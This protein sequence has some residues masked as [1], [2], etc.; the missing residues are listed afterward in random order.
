MNRSERRHYNKIKGKDSKNRKTPE[1][2]VVDKDK[3]NLITSTLIGVAI[4]VI[5]CVLLCKSYYKMVELSFMIFIHFIILNA[6]VITGI[7]L[8]KKKAK[9]LKTTIIFIVEY[10]I[11]G[12]ILLCTHTMTRY[13]VLSGNYESSLTLEEFK[14][15]A[16][17]TVTSES[18]IDGVWSD[19]IAGTD[20]AK[21]ETPQLKYDGVPGAKFYAIYMLDESA[22]NW[23]HWREYEVKTTILRQG[24]ENEN[25]D[26]A[27][28]N[29]PKGSGEHKYVVYVFALRD[30]PD[31][32]Y[33]GNFY[34]AGMGAEKYYEIDLDIAGKKRGNVISYGYLEGT[35]SQ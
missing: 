3:I 14:K 28:P 4:T 12:Y 35:Y 17:L 6:F 30:R 22:N 25:C 8:H 1:K 16:T 5:S 2:V 32:G 15:G 20:G 33:L 10:L 31:S 23:L 7:I 13:V 29:P 26:Y 9:R 11:L 18:L 21:N 27:G 34:E 19:D 24:Y